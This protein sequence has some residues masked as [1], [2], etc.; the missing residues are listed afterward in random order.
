[1]LA[2]LASKKYALN[3][4]KIDINQKNKKD[5]TTIYGNLFGANSLEFYHNSDY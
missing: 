3:N 1:M 4:D 5:Q 2:E